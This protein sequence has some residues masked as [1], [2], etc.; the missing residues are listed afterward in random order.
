MK[1]YLPIIIIM[2][3][4]AILIAIISKIIGGDNS[5]TLSAVIIGSLLPALYLF[6]KKESSNPHPHQDFQWGMHP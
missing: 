4:T 5:S 6:N 2:V 3:V 1:K